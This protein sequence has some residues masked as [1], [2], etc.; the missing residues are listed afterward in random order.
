MGYVEFFEEFFFRLNRL[1]IA[2]KKR[3]KMITTANRGSK[4]AEYGSATHQQILK[5][6]QNAV[7]LDLTTTICFKI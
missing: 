2:L 3:R 5:F 6:K 7:N 4:L 1:S